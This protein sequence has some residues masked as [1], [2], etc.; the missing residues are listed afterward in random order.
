M[1]DL[2]EYFIKTIP[3]RERVIQGLSLKIMSLRLN[4]EDIKEAIEGPN[5]EVIYFTFDELPEHHKRVS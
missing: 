4:D 3:A 1:N 2:V 5:V